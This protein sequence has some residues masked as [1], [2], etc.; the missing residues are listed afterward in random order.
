[1]TQHQVVRAI[2]HAGTLQLL[3][4][5]DLPEGVE[6]QVT[7]PVVDARQTPTAGPASPTRPADPDG[8]RQLCG[9][10]AVGGDALV[11]SEVLDDAGGD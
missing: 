8:L 5:V 7:L 1:M 6:L 3:E 9:L 4:P 11:D 10:I 2:Y